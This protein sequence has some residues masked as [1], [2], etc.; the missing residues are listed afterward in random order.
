[1]M[2]VF[3]SN[4]YALC[5]YFQLSFVLNLNDVLVFMGSLVAPHAVVDPLYFK[6]YFYNRSRLYK[7]IA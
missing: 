3:V 1:M 6:S 7:Y 4:G 5:I 2:K